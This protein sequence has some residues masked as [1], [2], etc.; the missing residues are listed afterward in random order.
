MAIECAVTDIDKEIRE[1]LIK[2][3]KDKARELGRVP[4]RTDFNNNVKVFCRVF[5]SWGN[6]LRAAGFPAR[7]L[8]RLYYRYL[9]GQDFKPTKEDCVEA[10]RR[11]SQEL[12]GYRPTCHDV[13]SE[14]GVKV[15]CPKWKVIV[16]LFGSFEA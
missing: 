9:Q 16:K 4:T 7:K 6:A 5:G 11:L 1:L 2:R 15:G 8:D 10:L 3:L 13:E 14:L 12:G